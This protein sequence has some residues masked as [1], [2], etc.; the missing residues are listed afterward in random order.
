MAKP[1]TKKKQPTKE[2]R[3]TDI[4]LENIPDRLARQSY[5]DEFKLAA[6]ARL[7]AGEVADTVAKELGIPSSSV[8]HNWKARVDKGLPV[9]ATRAGAGPRAAKSHE[10]GMA[11]GHADIASIRAALERAQKLR[12]ERL[13]VAAAIVEFDAEGDGRDIAKKI[14]AH[15][16]KVTP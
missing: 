4:P 6:V 12:D 14:R 9:T 10:R 13:E 5:T 1:T 3:G 15:I 2:K 8:L 11:D 7:K 16:R